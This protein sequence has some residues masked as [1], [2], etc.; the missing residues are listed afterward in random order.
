MTVFRGKGGLIINITCYAK[1]E[2]IIVVFC[3]LDATLQPFCTHLPKSAECLQQL[4]LD[5]D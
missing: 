2:V 1:L 5:W 3:S 4:K